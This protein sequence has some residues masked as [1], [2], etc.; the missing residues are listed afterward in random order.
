[1]ANALADDLNFIIAQTRPS[2]E[3]LRGQRL[4]LTGGTGFIGC[5]LLE[6]FLWA[7]EQL[8]LGASAVVLTR[9]PEA[10]AARAPHLA[11]HP[12]LS[13]HVGDVRSFDYP[14][15]A[16]AGVIH[17]AHDSRPAAPL[18]VL[19]TLVEGTRHTL[20]FA[21]HCGAQSFLLTSSG[22]VYGPQPPSVAQ[23]SE[24]YPGA[25]DP[26]L[27]ASVYGEGKRLA[28]LLCAL[29][30]EQHGLAI[31]IARC[32]AFTGPYLPLEANFA[33]GNF[34]RD[35]LAGG[36]IRVFG[37]GTPYR[38]YMYAADLA[39]WLWTLLTEGVPGRAYNVGAEEPISIGELAA[40]VVAQFGAA[41]AVEVAGTPTPGAPAARYVPSTARARDEL[42]LRTVTGLREGLQKMIAWN[43]SRPSSG[44]TAP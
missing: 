40:E 30:A 25:P 29:Y 22:A 16:F 15:G 17:A 19:D 23:V 14:P 28:E 6:S 20:D 12:A 18:E 44:S 42:G 13:L 38:S 36:P 3:A 37:D 8:G 10:F 31:K 43:Q 39:V 11:S 4:F 33:V 7:N 24:D 34:V 35:A 1:V 32:F 26:T 41:L 9:H 27:P 5:W 2:W 21:L